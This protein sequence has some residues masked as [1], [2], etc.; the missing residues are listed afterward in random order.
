MLQT[1]F[2]ITVHCTVH[3]YLFM[4]KKILAKGYVT[5]DQYDKENFKKL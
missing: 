4:K 1:I 2:Q 5:H 3:T